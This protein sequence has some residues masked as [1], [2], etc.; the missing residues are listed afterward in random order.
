MKTWL[1]YRPN[2]ECILFFFPFF[3]FSKFTKAAAAISLHAP[4]AVVS[5]RSGCVTSS[6]TVGTTVMNRDV[7]RKSSCKGSLQFTVTAFRNFLKG[8]M[9]ILSGDGHSKI[10]QIMNN[11]N[12]TAETLYCNILNDWLHH[13]CFYFFRQ[14][15]SRVLPWGVGMSELNKVYTSKQSVWQQTWLPWRNRWDQLYSTTDLRYVTKNKTQH[16]DVKSLN[17]CP[18][19]SHTKFW[20]VLSIKK[21][22]DQCMCWA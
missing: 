21:N 17:K 18:R 13:N 12:S 15:L 8:N 10:Y 1:D 7:V 9:L 2:V 19:N 14:W 3:Y 6:M 20:A 4:V 22:T 16:T 5:P 11:T